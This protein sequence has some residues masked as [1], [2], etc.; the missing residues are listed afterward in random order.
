MKFIVFKG[1]TIQLN[2]D[3]NGF[4]RDTQGTIYAFS[5]NRDSV[6]NRDVCGVGWFSLSDGNPLNRACGVH[7]YAYSS[8]VYQ[9][10]HSRQE[11]DYHLQTLLEQIPTAKGTITPYLFRAV[12][13]FLGGLFWENPET[14]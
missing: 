3:E 12:S 1:E 9:A 7:D 6:D 14:I 5:S 2:E 8:P 13:R 4:Y 11:A 10:Y